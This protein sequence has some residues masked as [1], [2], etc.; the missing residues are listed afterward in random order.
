MVTSP[1]QIDP[2]SS[3]PL[4]RIGPH[5]F[6]AKIGSRWQGLVSLARHV[7]LDRLVA[8][9]MRS[10]R[11]ELRS[12]AVQRFNQEM[13]AIGRLRHPNIIAATDAGVEAGCH[14]LVMEYVEGTDLGQLLRDQGP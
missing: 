5:T 6:L 1:S 8:L 14:Y 3:P 2:P 10:A 12:I 4:E 11:S 9:K 7:H 13:A